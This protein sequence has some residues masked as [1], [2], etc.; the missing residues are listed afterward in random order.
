[1]KPWPVAWYSQWQVFRQDDYT[2]RGCGIVAL[3]S[4]MEFWKPELVHVSFDELFAQGVARD[5]YLRGI[6]WKHPGLVEL[7]RHYGLAG[8]NADWAAQSRTP[9]TREESLDLLIAELARG[10]I[11]ASVWTRFNPVTKTGHL[12]VV[13][14]YD[15]GMVLLN[16][17]AA[18]TEETGR[19]AMTRERFLDAFRQRYICVYLPKKVE[20]ISKSG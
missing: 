7:A 11:I 3:R 1:M 4:I 9:R 17:P 8:H 16:D 2:S 15:E 6:G 14:G 20:N 13:T 12:V 19:L 10:P 18:R 5:A